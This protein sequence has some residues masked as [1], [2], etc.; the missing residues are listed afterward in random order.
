[1]TDKEVLQYDRTEHRFITKKYHNQKKSAKMKG[2]N[3]PSY[4]LDEFRVWITSQSN[5]NT[6]WGNWVNS[7]YNKDLCPSPDRKSDYL[8]YDLDNL[9]LMT[10]KE[11]KDKYHNDAKD[12][13]NNKLAQAVIQLNMKGEFIKEFH[14]SKS[15]G[16]ELTI[17]DGNIIANC[18]GRVKSAGGFKWIKKEDYER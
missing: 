9:T 11:N 15:A 8:S 5:W 12:G 7:G 13:V 18:K 6:L 3:P 14:S 17:P 4:S 2:Y 10:Y 16:R 1:M